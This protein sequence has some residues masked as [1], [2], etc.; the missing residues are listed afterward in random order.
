M[1]NYV[2]WY[3]SNY[4]LLRQTDWRNF[5]GPEEYET[6]V[7]YFISDLEESGQ[8]V[9]DLWDNAD[10]LE[11]ELGELQRENV[12]NKQEIHYP[13]QLNTLSVPVSRPTVLS[14]SGNY[15]STIEERYSLSSVYGGNRNS[16]SHLL[17]TYKSENN[18][19]R[20]RLLEVQGRLHVERQKYSETRVKKNRENTR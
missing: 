16:Y 19:L 11:S 2:E 3:G 1:K 6:E 8:E 13:K 12:R 20:K 9:A 5:K 10:A 15:V 18:D 14:S 4:S 7:K 17:E